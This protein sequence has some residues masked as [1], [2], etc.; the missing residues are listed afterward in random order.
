M[1]I[2]IKTAIISPTG[3]NDSSGFINNVGVG[4]RLW[5]VNAMLYDSNTKSLTSDIKKTGTLAFNNCLGTEGRFG[6]LFCPAYQLNRN[7]QDYGLLHLIRK[8]DNAGNTYKYRGTDNPILYDSKNGLKND[9][10]FL[11]GDKFDIYT[12][13]RQFVNYYLKQKAIINMILA[14]N[15]TDMI[16]DLMNIDQ[17]IQTADESLVNYTPTLD[18]GQE[19]GWEFRVTQIYDNKNGKID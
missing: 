16:Y 9:N 7:Y 11:Q 15:S 13:R 17:L 14:S 4:I 12:Y 2:R 3:L 6:T 1:P 10:L 5:H 19:I 18:F 8:D